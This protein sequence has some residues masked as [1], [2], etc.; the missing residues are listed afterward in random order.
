MS[1]KESYVGTLPAT[2]VAGHSAAL[3]QVLQNRANLPGISS[4]LD[5]AVM[6]A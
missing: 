3:L 4:S 1:Q 6:G 2:N 5:F